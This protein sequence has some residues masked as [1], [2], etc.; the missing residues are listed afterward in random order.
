MQQCS[1]LCSLFYV[2]F[3]AMFRQ[4]TQILQK[5]L[6]Y[7][8]SLACLLAED[9]KIHLPLQMDS[10]SSDTFWQQQNGWAFCKM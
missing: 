7:M 3:V 9:V 8:D 5:D 2:A 10:A 6:L 4:V 1:I